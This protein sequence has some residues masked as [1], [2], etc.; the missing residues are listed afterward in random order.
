MMTLINCSLNG[1]C[2]SMLILL[3]YHIC[4]NLVEMANCHQWDSGRVLK[5][6]PGSGKVNV[7]RKLF[8]CQH[9][10]EK[11]PL[12]EDKGPFGK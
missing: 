11:H 8:R 7:Y 10:S 1:A 6:F 2:D 9:K 12:I 5:T 4:C 3:V